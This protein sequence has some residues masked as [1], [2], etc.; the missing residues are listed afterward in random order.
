MFVSEG[1]PVSVGQYAKRK[2][3]ADFDT[4]SMKK[5]AKQLCDYYRKS[6]YTI[7]LWIDEMPADERDKRNAIMM[8]RQKNAGKEGFKGAQKMRFERCDDSAMRRHLE[9]ASEQL[10]AAYRIAAA[11]TGWPVLGRWA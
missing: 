5:N 2:R 9:Q 11:K 1:N 7:R 3:P 10:V 4:V 6:T 8:E